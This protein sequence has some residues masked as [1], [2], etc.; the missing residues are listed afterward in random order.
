MK[1]KTS[2]KTM[3]G[4]NLGLMFGLINKIFIELLTDILSASNQIKYVSLSSQKRITQPTLL[5]LNP[6][7]T[8]KNFTT[9]HLQLNETDELEVLIFL[10]TYPIKYV[11]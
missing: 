6:M 7:N 10:I 2:Y 8:V 4:F 11:F 3:F 9:I 5:D 1:K